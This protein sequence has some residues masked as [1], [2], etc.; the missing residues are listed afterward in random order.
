MERLTQV[1]KISLV[2]NY[3]T[4][5]LSHFGCFSFVPYRTY[6]TG[7]EHLLKL[8]SQCWECASFD[9]IANSESKPKHEFHEV[10][11]KFMEDYD[12]EYRCQVYQ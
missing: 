9:T 4:P 8:K 11:H 12:E 3:E 10:I 5:D 7:E 1:S 2:F 6:D